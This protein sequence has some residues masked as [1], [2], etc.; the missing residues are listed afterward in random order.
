VAHLINT[1]V[2]QNEHKPEFVAQDFHFHLMVWA[3]E[4]LFFGARRTTT[5]LCGLS[6]QPGARDKTQHLTP[7]ATKS[8]YEHT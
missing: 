7:Q 3:H 4:R 6:R 1:T 5:T 8:G 2:S